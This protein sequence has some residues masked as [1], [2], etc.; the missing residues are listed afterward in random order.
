[1]IERRYFIDL[2]W[3]KVR[4][5]LYKKYSLKELAVEFDTSIDKIRCSIIF[6]TSN[7]LISDEELPLNL[8]KQ[9][10][11]EIVEKIKTM[12][13]Q[14]MLMKNI[15]S[16]L[17]LTYNE[18]LFYWLKSDIMINYIE[19][20]SSKSDSCILLSQ[21]HLE[22]SDHDPINDKNINKSELIFQAIGFL[23]N[24][25]STITI[26]SISNYLGVCP[27][28]LRNWGVLHLIKQAK[29]NRRSKEDNNNRIN[30]VL[31]AEKIVNDML[32]NNEQVLSDEVYK[33]LGRKRNSIVRTYPEVTEQIN[34][35][36]KHGKL[37]YKLSNQ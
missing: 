6:L 23:N 8:P 4:T 31:S 2:A 14:G 25:N 28:T 33:K 17:C 16:E 34:K 26:K 32:L 20:N 30:L 19:R 1:M 3:N 27:E 35:I 13:N 11:Y 18:L 36:I 5:S 21:N 15:K 9:H 37:E 22:V 12:I 29:Q 24:N 10:D 7:N